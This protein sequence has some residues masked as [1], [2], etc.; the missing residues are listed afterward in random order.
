MWNWKEASI[1]LCKKY[2]PRVLFQ[3][4]VYVKSNFFNVL[5]RNYSSNFDEHKHYQL[6]EKFPTDSIRNVGVIAHIDAGKT[7][8][9]ERILYCASK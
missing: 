7:T 3:N 6:N 5:Y 4:Y 9:T 8:T 1:L 2:K